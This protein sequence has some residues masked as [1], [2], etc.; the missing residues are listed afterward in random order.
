VAGAGH[1]I[2]DAGTARTGDVAVGRRRHCLVP[3]TYSS[4]K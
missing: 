4:R 2:E 1:L 3:A